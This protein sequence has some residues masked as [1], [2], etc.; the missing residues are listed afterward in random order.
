MA[1]Q[2]FNINKEAQVG[3]LKSGVSASFGLL[4]LQVDVLSAVEGEKTVSFTNVCTGTEGA[5]HPPSKINSIYRCPQCANEDKTILRKAKA[6]GKDEFVIVP[7]EEIDAANSE[8]SKFKDAMSITT[9]PSA[10]VLGKTLET[11]S[12]YYLAPSSPAFAEVYALIVHMV[13]SNPETAFVTMWAARSAPAMYR[14]DVRDDV[15]VLRQLAWPS[16]VQASPEVPT[17]FNPAFESQA[18]LFVDSTKADF[19]PDTYVDVRGTLLDAYVA[20][21][22]TVQGVAPA[23]G[24]R[25]AAPQGLDIMALL[26]AGTPEAGTPA[27]KA[28]AK[29]TKAPAKKSA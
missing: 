26:K 8:A 5:E 27:K 29:R 15:L 24:E 21:Q 22:S 6:Q 28:A 9:H 14:L 23:G 3:K 2:G 4:P 13:K 20:S 19:D 25:V 1:R 17:T 7:Q 18:Q 10:D 16:Q 11:G 12:M